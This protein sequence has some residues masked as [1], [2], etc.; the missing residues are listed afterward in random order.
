MVAMVT[1]LDGLWDAFL[2]S[3]AHHIADCD[4]VLLVCTVKVIV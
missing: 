2:A 4:Q 1:K 3:P